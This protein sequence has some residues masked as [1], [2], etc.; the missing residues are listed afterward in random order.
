M[1]DHSAVAME[2][3]I[4]HAIKGKAGPVSGNGSNWYRARAGDRG[5]GAKK[6]GLGP[7]QSAWRGSA[8]KS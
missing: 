3:V 4:D 1:S 8:E 2:V 5:R 7:D 6:G